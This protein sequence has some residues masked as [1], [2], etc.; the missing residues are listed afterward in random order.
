ML[1]AGADIHVRDMYGRGALHPAAQFCF[2]GRDSLRARRMLDLLLRHGADADAA[3]QDAR[4][5]LLLLLG[6]HAKP[7]TPCDGTH[8]GALVPVL[9]EAG[10]DPRHAD[11]RGMTALH[12]CAMHML[13]GAA[14][15]LLANGAARDAVDEQGRTPA[16]LARELGYIDVAVELES[17]QGVP[18]VSQTLRRPAD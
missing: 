3:D 1:A 7:G 15:V 4:T 16:E 13:V 9:L 10:A 11:R 17:R 14:R 18:G 6:A 2:A 5:P 8:L 12:A